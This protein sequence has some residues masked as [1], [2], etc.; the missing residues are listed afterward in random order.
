MIIESF[1]HNMA[2]HCESGALAALIKHKGYAMIKKV[3]I[4]ITLISLIGVSIK[5]QDFELDATSVC[6]ITSVFY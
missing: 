2:A 6:L 4:F 5:A 1:K 3:L